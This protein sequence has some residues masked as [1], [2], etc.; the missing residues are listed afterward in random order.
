MYYTGIGSRNTPNDIIHQI[1]KLASSLATDGYTL[2]SG[3]AD[4]ADYA[5]EH[6]SDW[7]G[8]AKEIYIPWEG[9]NN[10]Y[11]ELYQPSE[12]AYII[13]EDIYGG[14]WKHISP[15]VKALMARNMHQVMG[16]GLD[17]KSMFV[18]CW[19]PDGCTKAKDRTKRTGGTGQAIAYADN[20]SI[21]VFN[22]QNENE[23]EKLKQ[24]IETI[25][26]MEW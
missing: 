4:G 19:T 6:G 16:E 18:V 13:A 5:F 11:S 12:E 9:F 23:T 25:G 8:G 24:Y 14:R 2:R 15:A 10:S 26:V 7:I 17:E 1:H 3:A 22:L 20:M 21:P